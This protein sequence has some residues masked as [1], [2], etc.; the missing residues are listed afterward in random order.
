[1]YSI[2]IYIDSVFKH[3]CKY[4]NIIYKLETQVESRNKLFFLN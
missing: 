2:I 4:I 1:M 3:Y